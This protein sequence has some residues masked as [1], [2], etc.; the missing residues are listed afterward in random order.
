MERTLIIEFEA[1]RQEA[2]QERRRLL[3]RQQR[4]LAERDKLL[5]AHYAEAVPL[6]LLKSEQDRI[7]GPLSQIIERLARTEFEYNACETNLVAALKFLE[8]SYRTYLDADE[9]LRRQ[10]NQALFKRINIDRG[11][12]VN[13]DLTEPFSSLLSPAVRDLVAA[14]DSTSD[15]TDWKAREDS[16]N[17]NTREEDPAGVGLTYETMVE[18]NGAL[19]N[20]LKRVK[21]P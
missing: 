21:R 7:R 17:D 8:N 20:P 10:I 14:K 19:W 18:L 13:A 3:K 15:V 1:V 16:F 5:Q 4:L 11:G 2:D 6:D 9:V 12:K